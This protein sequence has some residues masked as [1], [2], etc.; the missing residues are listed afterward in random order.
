MEA[1]S[2][3][4]TD[5]PAWFLDTDSNGLCFHVTQAHFPRTGAWGNL[6][7]ALRAGYDESVWEHRTALKERLSKPP[8][9]KMLP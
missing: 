8:P 4:G 7:K 2:I 6:R 5:I 1:T 3:E 9:T